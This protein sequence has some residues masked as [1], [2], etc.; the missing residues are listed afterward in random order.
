[1][2]VFFVLTDFSS[3]SD[4]ALT[5]RSHVDLMTYQTHAYLATELF[6][7]LCETW[8]VT[9]S[10]KRLIKGSVKPDRS[11]LFVR[12]PHFWRY[13]RGFVI[14]KIHKLIRYRLNPEKKNKKFSEDLGI[15]LHYVADF[16]TAAHNMKPNKLKVHLAFEDELH[17]LFLKTVTAESLRTTLRLIRGDT[18]PDS[19][20]A[21]DPEK[22]LRDLHKRY[23]PDTRSPQLDITEIVTACM[24]VTAYVMDNISI[25]G[26]ESDESDKTLLR[27]IS[28]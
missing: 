5:K 24:T 1:M 16:F 19:L 27:E 20:S 2:S 4:T 7:V 23:R 9:L 12:H 6:P 25:A 28:V 21:I 15:V 14:R 18:S 8:N 17:D 11:S 3:P 26:L 22:V 10:K 13:S